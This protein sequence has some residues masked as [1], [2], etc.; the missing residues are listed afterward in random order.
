MHGGNQICHVLQVAFRCDHL[1][2]VVGIGFIHTVFIGGIM[3]DLLFLC[4]TDL[5]CVDTECHTIL[6]SKVAED[7]LFFRAGRVFPQRPYTAI[8]I[9]ADKVVGVELDYRGSDHIQIG[10]DLDLLCRGYRR[11]DFFLFQFNT[12]YFR[13][14]FGPSLGTR[15]SM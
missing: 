6:F 7:R 4:R 2:Q 15:P 10:F 5:P 13:F 14:M 12:S 9:A 3:D 1:L 8:G 11:F